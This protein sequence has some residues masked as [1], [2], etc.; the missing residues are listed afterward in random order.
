M[1]EVRELID[2]VVAF[3]A[4]LRLDGERLILTPASKVPPEL[5]TRLRERKPDLLAYLSHRTAPCL[6]VQD[7]WD[8]ISERATILEFDGGMDRDEANHRAFMLWYRRFVED[9]EVA[10]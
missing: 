8:R 3:G 4:A 10:R 9:G 7:S 6:D 2:A 5:K 1:T